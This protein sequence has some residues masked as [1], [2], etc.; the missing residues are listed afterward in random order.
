MNRLPGWPQQGPIGDQ[1]GGLH[2]LAGVG[3]DDPGSFDGVAGSGL[4]GRNFAQESEGELPRSGPRWTSGRHD[5]GEDP[6]SARRGRPEAVRGLNHA[7]LGPGRYGWQYPDAYTAIG[8]L[9]QMVGGIT[10]ALEQAWTPLS[11]LEGDGHIRST[12]DTVARDMTGARKT[13]DDAR[14][15]SDR[16]GAA[17]HRAHNATSPLAYEA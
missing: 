13:L 17:L 7:T 3:A 8:G 2:A 16:L 4:D 5:R 15:S 11:S 9:E 12:R 14:E 10:Q 1:V 6:R